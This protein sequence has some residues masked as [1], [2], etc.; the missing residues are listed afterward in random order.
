MSFL[1]S[2]LTVAFDCEARPADQAS[3]KAG[4]DQGRRGSE[5]SE[6]VAGRQDE[7]GA[8]DWGIQGKTHKLHRRAI[9][10]T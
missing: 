1:L 6:G 3:R 9:C 10:E 2:L 4:A 7:R 5:R 8:G